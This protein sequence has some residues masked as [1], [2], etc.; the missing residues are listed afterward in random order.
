V[1]FNEFNDPRRRPLPA[2]RKTTTRPAPP[3]SLMPGPRITRDDQRRLKASAALH[4][5]SMERRLAQI[6]AEA[7]KDIPQP[8]EA[9]AS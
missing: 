7:L 3:D 5:V 9:V 4:G 6:L 8:R 2:T 1:E